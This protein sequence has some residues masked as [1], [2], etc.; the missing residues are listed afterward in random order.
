MPSCQ[1]QP[2]GLCVVQYQSKSGA[3]NRLERKRAARCASGQRRRVNRC[4]RRSQWWCVVVAVVVGSEVVAERA[5][6]GIET[7]LLA[8]GPNEQ[9]ASSPDTACAIRQRRHDGH[10][11]KITRPS[12]PPPRHPSSTS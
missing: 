10:P 9:V 3:A 6:E 11:P 8:F 4:L 7:T 12:P 5:R 2:V 1:C